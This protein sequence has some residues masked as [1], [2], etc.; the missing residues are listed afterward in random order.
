MST[1]DGPS[2]RASRRQHAHTIMTALRELRVQ[3]SLLNR[4]VGAHAELK[5]VDVDCF[6]LVN[7]EGPMSPTALARRAGLHPATM[8][9]VLDRLERGGW[10]TRE[11]DFAD[12]RAVTVQAVRGRA[13]ELVRLYA[14]LARGIDELCAGYGEDDLALVADFVRRAT[15]AGRQATDALATHRMG[16][17]P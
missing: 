5:D 15:L 7:R 12:R 14:G 9:G 1:V 4:Q 8:T 6:E 2:A 13:A 16:G 11:R 17:S 3:L 10:V